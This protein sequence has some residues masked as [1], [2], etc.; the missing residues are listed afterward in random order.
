MELKFTAATDPFAPPA[1]DAAARDNVQAIL[2]FNRRWID[3][4]F[5]AAAK[6]SVGRVG[7][8]GAGW[9]GAAIAAVVIRH[10]TSVAVTDVSGE[11][12][13]KFPDS[14]AAALRRGDVTSQGDEPAINPRDWITASPDKAI[15]RDCDLVMESVIENPAVKQQVYRETEPHLRGV[16]TTNTSTLPMAR[17]SSVL[18]DPS[19][20]CGTHFFMPVHRRPLVEIV[21][22]PNTA[23]ATVAKA[24]AFVR[25]IGRIPLVVNDGPGFLVNRL[26]MVY[27]GEA[28][29]LLMEGADLD[30]VDRAGFEF[31][32]GLGPLSLVDSTGMDVAL[33]CGWVFAGAYPDILPRTPLLVALKKAGRIGRKNGAGFWTYDREPA[34]DDAP[35][36]G[37]Q[38]PAG[39]R[40]PA[41][42]AII[43]KW[44]DTPREYA[45]ATIARRLILPM[46]LEGTR[47]LRDGTVD[48]PRLVDL[49]VIFGLGFPESR[50]GLFYWADACGANR[51]VEMLGEF[52]YL[53]ARMS[54]T[55][56]LLQA[57]EQGRRL[58]E[59]K[60]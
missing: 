24:V 9:M 6:A 56:M 31:G 2:E 13:E 60:N 12:L 28:L 8:I 40:D 29:Q 20:F 4:R 58:Y 57:A 16:L 43:A 1:N 19:R 41:A 26:Y 32:M 25:A 22:G 37:Q 23:D 7:I 47:I 59:L 52:G 15:L 35:A 18:A 33:D 10:R 38:V 42:D 55:P 3:E 36:A 51:F 27:A 45:P 46:L 49:A 39:R 53:G 34:D 50:G 5:P 30:A 14:V 17:L 21:R 44:A 11:M 54:P 48:D